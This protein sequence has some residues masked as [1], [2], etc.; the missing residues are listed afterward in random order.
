MPKT[1]GKMVEGARQA[2]AI[3]RGRMTKGFRVHA[4]ETLDERAIR[5]RTQGRELPTGAAR[6]NASILCRPSRS[7]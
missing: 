6:D 4:P 5:A 1:K 3:A 7:R 2:L